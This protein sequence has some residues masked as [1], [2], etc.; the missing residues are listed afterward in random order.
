M[1]GWQKAGLIAMA[2]LVAAIALGL[3]VYAAAAS[4]D[5]VA[6]LAVRKGV[7]LPRLNPLG[8]DGG[9]LGV[10]VLNVALTWIRRT[11]WW[12][13]MTARL[14][15]AGM[16]AAN[17]A[18][19]WPDPVGV[20]LRVAAPVLF[21]IIVEAACAVLLGWNRGPA[22]RIPIARWALAPR[23]TFAIWKRKKLWADS[24]LPKSVI[25]AELAVIR[26][27]AHY[28]GQWAEEAPADLV[29][30]VRAGVDMDQVLARVA[31]LTAPEPLPEAVPSAP[32]IPARRAAK[33]DP[34]PRRPGRRS[35]PQEVLST[36]LRAFQLLQEHPE[37][38][39]PRM[40]AELARQLGVHPSYGGKLHRR[41]TAQGAPGN[42][43]PER[44]G[45]AP[46]DQSQERS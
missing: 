40:G 41:L 43:S 7:S 28:G 6:H 2:A 30:M 19:G 14:F 15:A 38:R 29:W 22:E 13:R 5:T 20:G 44:S 46:R 37:L 25:D 26:L 8:I 16:I 12:L 17:A 42:Q 34:G 31:E 45:I 21:I 4:Y 18:A 36:E 9:L 27:A 33:S 11:I 23:A 35:T 3:A 24:R 10:I 1:T 39:R 32:A